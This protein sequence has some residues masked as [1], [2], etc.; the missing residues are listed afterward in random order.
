[1]SFKVIKRDHFFVPYSLV[2]LHAHQVCFSFIG[3][4]CFFFFRLQMNT[5]PYNNL[6]AISPK[7]YQAFTLSFHMW[8][9]LSIGYHVSKMNRPLVSNKIY[10]QECNNGL[11]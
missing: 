11:F 4:L 6:L 7:Y 1:M 3:V 2:L 5:K 10:S 8:D 9:A